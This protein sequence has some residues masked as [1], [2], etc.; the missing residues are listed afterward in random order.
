MGVRGRHEGPGTGHYSALTPA[1]CQGEREDAPEAGGSGDG[2]GRIR[3]QSRFFRGAALREKGRAIGA[4][5]TECAGYG[6]IDLPIQ[7]RA[8]P[9]DSGMLVG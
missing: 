1:L 5:K 7:R 8:G 9:L 4:R 6:S 3:A 2:G